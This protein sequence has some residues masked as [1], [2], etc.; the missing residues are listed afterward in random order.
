[1]CTAPPGAKLSEWPHHC[2]DCQKKIHTA[3]WWGKNWGEYV[4]SGVFK[5][6][7]D[8]LS[9][10]GRESI[11]SIDHKMLTIC[12]NCVNRLQSTAT[13]E[14]TLATTAECKQTLKNNPLLFAC[15]MMSSLPPVVQ[16]VHRRWRR[17]SQKSQ[18]T[19]PA[20]RASA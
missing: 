2:L 10:A 1:M 6:N 4:D 5:I 19:T 15:G 3:I 11:Q 12:H 13:S 17:V 16:T 14:S 18:K 20:C 9:I 8:Q 7:V